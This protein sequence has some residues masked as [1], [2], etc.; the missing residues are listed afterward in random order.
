MPSSIPSSAFEDQYSAFY[1]SIDEIES[2]VIRPHN[3]DSLISLRSSSITGEADTTTAKSNA[4]N[5]EQTIPSLPPSS[6]QHTVVKLLVDPIQVVLT[7]SQYHTL[8]SF[9]VTSIQ[10]QNGRPNHSPILDRID[11]RHSR[12]LQLKGNLP[13]P[14]ASSTSTSPVSF[15]SPPKPEYKPRPSIR[16]W[17]RYLYHCVVVEIRKEKPPLG[18]HQIEKLRASYNLLYKAHLTSPP[19]P[20]DAQEQMDSIEDKLSIE[21]I[22]IFRSLTRAK[23]QQIA[24]NRPHDSPS[25]MSSSAFSPLSAFTSDSLKSPSHYRNFVV[26]KAAMGA[27]QKMKH[28]YQEHMS[29]MSAKGAGEKGEVK[30]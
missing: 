29:P 5:S 17:W 24:S 28:K 27:V 18:F 2:Y 25:S 11:P 19:L 4:A 3:I 23:I 16:A 14:T 8:N 12:F 20:P 21:Q 15:S 22:L 30:V 26:A 9:L 10:V 1:P 6:N 7:T 13:P